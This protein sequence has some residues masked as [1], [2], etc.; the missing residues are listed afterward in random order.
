[1][2]DVINNIIEEISEELNIEKD[3]VEK[4]VRV[5]CDWTRRNL[6]NME[7]PS[8]L[9]NYFGKF[10]IIESRLKEDSEEKKVLEEFNKTFK[11]LKNNDKN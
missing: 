10:S 11:K 3:K 1:M 8:I 9:W 2:D 6:I 4:S 7:Y 5:V